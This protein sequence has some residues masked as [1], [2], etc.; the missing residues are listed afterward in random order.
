MEEDY[1]TKNKKERRK[2]YIKQYNEQNKEALK[3]YQKDYYQANKPRIQ[4]YLKKYTER[5]KQ[6]SKEGV[7]SFPEWAFPKYSLLK[8][9]FFKSCF[10]VS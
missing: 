2:K 8:N 7:G 1:Y 5:K 10:I 4:E 6:Y 9:I 3:E